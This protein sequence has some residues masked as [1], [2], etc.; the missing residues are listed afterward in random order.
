[1]HSAGQRR[2]RLPANR[3]PRPLA[4]LPPCPGRP[5]AGVAYEMGLVAPA[6]YDLLRTKQEVVE[7]LVANGQWLEAHTQREQLLR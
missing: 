6:V 5:P 1:M 4:H 7:Q 2:R 3:P